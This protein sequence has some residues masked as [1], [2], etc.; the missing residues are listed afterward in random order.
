MLFKRHIMWVMKDE[1]LRRIGVAYRVH[2]DPDR[3]IHTVVRGDDFLSVSTQQ[4]LY[5]LDTL[6]TTH[7]DITAGPHVGP[8]KLGGVSP[9]SFLERHRC[10]AREEVGKTVLP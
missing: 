7:F 6:P 3:K 4:L 5:W 2:W 1:G 10:T 9:G 8:V